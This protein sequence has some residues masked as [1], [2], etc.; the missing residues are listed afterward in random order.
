MLVINSTEH[1]HQALISIL[2]QKKSG[3]NQS[4]GFRNR[5]QRDELDSEDVSR[6][7]RLEANERSA[8]WLQ[9][10]LG[11]LRNYAQYS[12]TGNN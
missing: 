2:G 6:S 7:Y 3:K 5:V 8:P 1:E 12:D 4:N 11:I 10:Q 9:E